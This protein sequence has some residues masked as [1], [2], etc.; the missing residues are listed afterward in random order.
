M[1]YRYGV[2]GKERLKYCPSRGGEQKSWLTSRTNL[3]KTELRRRND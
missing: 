2:L 1:G 3:G